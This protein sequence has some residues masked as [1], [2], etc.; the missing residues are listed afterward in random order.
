MA[1][2][3]LWSQSKTTLQALLSSL[4]K[5]PSEPLAASQGGGRLSRSLGD[6]LQGSLREA[7]TSEG[8]GWPLDGTLGTSG[9]GGGG[10]G[11]FF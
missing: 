4:R 1:L 11:R 5:V 8:C 10:K 3:H 6:R 7:S 9:R 2:S